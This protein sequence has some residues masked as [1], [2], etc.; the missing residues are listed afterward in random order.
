[1]AP[2]SWLPG[3]LSVSGAAPMLLQKAH[4]LIP[5]EVFPVFPSTCLLIEAADGRW[6]S[7]PWEGHP[8]QAIT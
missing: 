2:C 7:L 3:V 1:M 8:L 6:A 4:F 5:A